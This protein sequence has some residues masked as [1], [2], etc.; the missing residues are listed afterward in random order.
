MEIYEW[1]V[2][3]IT[4]LIYLIKS[5]LSKFSFYVQLLLFTPIF[6]A[7]VYKS[8]YIPKPELILKLKVTKNKYCLYVW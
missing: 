3:V 7:V 5:I 6:I 2:F 4:L 8:K 1:N